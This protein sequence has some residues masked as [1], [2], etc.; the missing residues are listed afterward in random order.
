MIRDAITKVSLNYSTLLFIAI[1]ILLIIAV[2]AQ[3]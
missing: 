1:G 3:Q 2:K